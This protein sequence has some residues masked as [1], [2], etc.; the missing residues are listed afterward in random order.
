MTQIKIPILL[1]GRNGHFLVVLPRALL[2]LAREEFL[3][4]YSSLR[5]ALSYA[6][7]MHA[8]THVGVPVFPE[9][10]AKDIW[11]PVYSRKKK[12]CLG[13]TQP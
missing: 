6:S 12:S 7:M 11:Y 10:G 8:M 3:K 2:A 1:Y 4:Y 5:F 13:L 9:M